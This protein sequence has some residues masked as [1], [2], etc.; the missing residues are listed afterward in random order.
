MRLPGLIALRFVLSAVLLCATWNPSGHSWVHSLRALWPKV[1]GLFALHTV[2]LTIAWV[3]LLRAIWRSLGLL[4]VVL[5]AALL[6]ALVWVA[7]DFGLLELRDAT[8][9]SWLVLFLVTV[10]HTIGLS[11]GDVKRRVNGAPAPNVMPRG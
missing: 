6:G 5:L 7:V 4:G 8:F 10:V 9:T 11:F 2:V 3:A 1:N